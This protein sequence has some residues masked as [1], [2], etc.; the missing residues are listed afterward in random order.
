MHSI[1]DNSKHGNQGIK[2]F[3]N[4]LFKG[5]N[6]YKNCQIKSICWPIDKNSQDWSDCK[7]FFK[8]DNLYAH[9]IYTK[10]RDKYLLRVTWEKSSQLRQASS[11]SR[12]ELDRCQRLN[13]SDFKI[14]MEQINVLEASKLQVRNVMENDIS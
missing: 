13:E 2:N 7:K 8:D 10:I 12:F 11:V 3:L 6:R 14:R 1:K 9:I 5:T 4:D